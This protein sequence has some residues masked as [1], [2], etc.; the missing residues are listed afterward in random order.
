VHADVA[1]TAEYLAENDADWA[2]RLAANITCQSAV[3]EQLPAREN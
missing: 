3:D 2:L 1:G